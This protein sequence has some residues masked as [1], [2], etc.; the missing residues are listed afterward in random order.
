MAIAVGDVV[1]YYDGT[2]EE[3]LRAWPAMV[4]RVHPEVLGPDGCTTECVDLECFG[5]LSPCFVARATRSQHPRAFRWTMR[6]VEVR[7]NYGGT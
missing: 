3:P 7:I 5:Y 6:K 2:P 4:T 1:M